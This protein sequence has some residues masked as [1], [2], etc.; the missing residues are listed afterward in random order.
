MKKSNMMSDGFGTVHFL[1]GKI[2]RTDGP[3]IEKGLGHKEWWFNGIEITTENFEHF[4]FK[5]PDLVEQY[6]LYL[7][8][9]PVKPFELLKAVVSQETD[10]VHPVRATDKYGN[11]IYRLNGK[12]HRTDGPAVELANGTKYWYCDNILHRVDGPAIEGCDGTKEWFVN[13]GEHRIDGPALEHA[14]GTKHWYCNNELHRTDGP[15]IERP[16]GHKE[17]WVRNEQISSR[18]CEKFRSSYPELVDQ[19]LAYTPI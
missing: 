3:A 13:G 9:K 18:N 2:H 7:V 16:N 6:L 10:S 11:A 19:F 4:R 15:A 14:N 12:I 1:N 5:C 8:T 17:W